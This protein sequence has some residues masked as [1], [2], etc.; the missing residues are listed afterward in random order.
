MT[1]RHRAGRGWSKIALI[2]TPSAYHDV[3]IGR[4]SVHHYISVKYCVVRKIKLVDVFD[5]ARCRCGHGL[6]IFVSDKAFHFSKIVAVFHSIQ[7]I[8]EWHFALT[9]YESGYGR[10]WNVWVERCASAAGDLQNVGQ[11]LD[12]ARV[13]FEEFR[14]Q[15]GI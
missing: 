6:A 1:R 3:Y 9:N 7:Q 11:R 10:I 12:S 5:E 4:G 14:L 8:I 2:R 15:G 13:A